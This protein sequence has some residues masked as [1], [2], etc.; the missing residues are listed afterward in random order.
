MP[1][2]RSRT[3]RSMLSIP[4]FSSPTG[5]RALNLYADHG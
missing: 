4:L 3:A 1:A 5:S 2:S